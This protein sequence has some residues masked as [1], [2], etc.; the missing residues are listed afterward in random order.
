[1]MEN[2]VFV[3]PP[4][5]FD[6]AAMDR[7]ANQARTVQ[8]VGGPGPDQERFLRGFAADVLPALRALGRSA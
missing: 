6:E 1:M 4:G 3:T 8:V 2:W 7:R 5:S